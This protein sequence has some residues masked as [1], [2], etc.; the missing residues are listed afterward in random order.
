MYV[1]GG[2]TFAIPYMVKQNWDYAALQCLEVRRPSHCRSLIITKLII[3][4]PRYM[5]IYNFSCITNNTN[6]GVCQKRRCRNNL[7]YI[8]EIQ[9]RYTDHVRFTFTRSV[10]ADKPFICNF[11]N[12]TRGIKSTERWQLFLLK[13]VRTHPRVVRNMAAPVPERPNPM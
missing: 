10:V 11:W 3:Q 4:G 13:G 2:R 12:T 9:H 8:R 7:S 5:N 1:T 6:C